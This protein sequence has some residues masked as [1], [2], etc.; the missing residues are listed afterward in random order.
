MAVGIVIA[1]AGDMML[2]LF[3]WWCP[4]I[5]DV[6]ESFAKALADEGVFRLN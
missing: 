4:R 5:E 6:P 1:I 3:V 2:F